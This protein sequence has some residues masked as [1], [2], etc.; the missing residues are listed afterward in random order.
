MIASLP[1]YDR[2][3]CADANDRYWAEIRDRC[4]TV[5]IAAPNSLTR[6]KNDLWADWMSA[7]LLFSQTCGFPFRARLHD[8]VTLIGT[9]DFG[10][11]GCAP[12][13][14]YSVLVVRGDD[15]RGGIDAFSGAPL[16]YNE[17]MSQSG[18]AAPWR[19][20]TDRG[21]RISPQLETGGHQ[22]SAQAVADGKADLAALDAVTWRLI[23]AHE[24]ALAARLRVIGETAPTPGLP[25]ITARSR[26]G[27]I[28]FGIVADAIAAL[29]PQ[30]RTTLGL[31]GM[32]A[33]PAA[34][35]LAVPIPPPPR[36]IVS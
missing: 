25:Y 23:R 36:Q 12:G 14:Y 30:D 1:M 22:L 35:Y 32:V 33:I 28:L 16:A 9:P 2:V 10:I 20:F 24:P 19:Y 6:G 15:R 5:G 29:S 7:D 27:A 31:H 17:A 34:D 8:K 18:W 4:R 26:D 13:Y 3:E 11:E 21:L